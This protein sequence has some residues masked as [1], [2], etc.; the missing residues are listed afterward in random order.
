[1]SVTT[2]TV[3]IKIKDDATAGLLAVARVMSGLRSTIHMVALAYKALADAE[4][5]AKVAQGDFVSVATVAFRLLGIFAAGT[6]TIGAGTLAMGGGGG[7]IP[8]GQTRMGEARVLT[9]SGPVWGHAGETI[10]RLGPP[11]K[12]GAG[13]GN[14][15]VQADN[16]NLVRDG[17][18]AESVGRTFAHFRAGVLSTDVP[19]S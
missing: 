8:V 5:M 2:R 3:N 18:D 7:L 4:L 16:I 9:S 17:E 1:M 15:T 11:E 14:F 13:G 10:G 12:A 6:R 19:S